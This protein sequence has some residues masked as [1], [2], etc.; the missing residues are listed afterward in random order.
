MWAGDPRQQ[1]Q[2]QQATRR[3]KLPKATDRLQLGL[4]GLSVSPICIGITMKP[5]TIP[6]AFD[7]GVNFFFLT[8]DLHWPLYEGV[9]RGLEL[10]FSRGAAIRDQVIV[11]VVSYLDQPLFGALQFNEVIDSVP[12]LQ[13]IDLLI[14]GAISN[15]QS[16]NDRLSA[17][18]NARGVSHCGSRAIGGSFHDRRCALLS[19]N[20]NCLDV[21]YVRY[22]T[23]H[24][25]ADADIFPYVR[26]D[27]K[28]LIFNFKSVLSMVTPEHLRRL[29]L[30]GD[31]WLP[32]V[33]DYYRFVLTNPYIDG[34]LCSPAS[35]EQLT[36]LLAALE[37]RPFTITEEQYMVWLSSAATPRYF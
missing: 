32:K 12:G 24:P 18:Y 14:A 11:G 36:E 35:P 29:G 7:A 2:M 19:L 30:N 1:G 31:I 28:G 22:N 25:G 3:E 6:A 37:E 13:R 8:A 33:T 26:R 34:V 4:S 9:R 23:A 17:I 21:N 15:E 16:F 27:R 5:E 10:L 20:Y